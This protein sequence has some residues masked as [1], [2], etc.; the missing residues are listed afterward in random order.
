MRVGKGGKGSPGAGSSHEIRISVSQ[1]YLSVP[2]ICTT[3][4]GE[5]NIFASGIRTFLPHCYMTDISVPIYPVEE[6]FKRYWKRTFFGWLPEGRGRGG[7]KA[8]HLSME[9]EKFC[10]S[11]AAATL[12]IDW[13]GVVS[14]SL[15]PPPF[16]LK[17]L[18][19]RLRN[20]TIQRRG[21][22]KSRLDPLWAA[23]SRNTR[24]K[25]IHIQFEYGK[26]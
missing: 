3:Y 7:E 4:Q 20:E 26:E 10:V 25:I 17:A 16:P 6:R 23:D 1:I 8:T 12:G 11:S 21:E 9:E 19:C 14:S 13:V 22:E 24:K 18:M 15:D 5:P 2:R